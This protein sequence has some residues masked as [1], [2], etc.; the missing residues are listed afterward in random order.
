MGRTV[1][2]VITAGRT[3]DI[4]D[5]G[6]EVNVDV[7]ETIEVGGEA[8]PTMTATTKQLEV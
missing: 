6:S 3:R 4:E 8:I 5:P 7:V 2:G 1:V